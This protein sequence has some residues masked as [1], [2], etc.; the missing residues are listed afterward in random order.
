MLTPALALHSV[1]A[2]P[3]CPRMYVSEASHLRAER[4]QLLVPQL[5]WRRAHMSVLGAFWAAAVSGRRPVVRL[6]PEKLHVVREV[7]AF[8]TDACIC[9]W[10]HQKRLPISCFPSLP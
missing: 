2:Q 8:K 1:L 9:V 4:N 6:L 3:P 10:E 5:H 7:G